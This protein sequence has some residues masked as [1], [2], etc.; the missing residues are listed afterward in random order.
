MLPV[1]TKANRSG[2]RLRVWLLGALHDGHAKCTYE[3]TAHDEYLC[4]VQGSPML[5][6]PEM[7]SKRQCFVKT[8]IMT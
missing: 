3:W 7:T 1:V 2:L 6:G 5:K 4:Y 8:H